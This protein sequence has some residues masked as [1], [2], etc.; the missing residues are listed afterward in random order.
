MIAL[1][2]GAAADIPVLIDIWRRSVEATH[3]FLTPDD[4]ATLEPEGRRALAM[5]EVWVAEMDGVP[6]GF[7]MLNDTMI[8]ALF[9]DP[10]HMGKGLGTRLIDHARELRGRDKELR[11]DVN[12][13][14]PDA[15]GFYLAKGFKQ[16]G[17]SETDS[18]GRPWPLL[19]LVLPPC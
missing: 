13:A 9:I 6:A 7:M 2:Q 5:L 16:V 10:P 3:S 4:I 15:L 18:A 8:E 17:R 12:E 11:L 19:H 14:N 1:R